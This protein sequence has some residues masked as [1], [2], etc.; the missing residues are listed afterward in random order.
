M[1]YLNID[2]IH[3]QVIGCLKV[4]TRRECIA[5]VLYKLLVL[6]HFDHQL[7]QEWIRI[8]FMISLLYTPCGSRYPA[9]PACDVSVYYTS[10]RQQSIMDNRQERTTTVSGPTHTYGWNTDVRFNTFLVLIRYL[11]IGSQD[12][13][14]DSA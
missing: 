13:E 7:A 9:K 8:G 10:S 2:E 1:R 12:W 5:T 14:P 11:D 6:V 4:E 3:G